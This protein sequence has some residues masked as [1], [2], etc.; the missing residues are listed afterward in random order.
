MCIIENLFVWS[1]HR[2]TGEIWHWHSQ[3]EEG[4]LREAGYYGN[5]REFSTM[6]CHSLQGLWP[7]C[8]AISLPSGRRRGAAATRAHCHGNTAAAADA[9]WG[10]GAS[11][12][13]QTGETP[14]LCQ[15]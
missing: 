1:R 5:Q 7:L 10:R 13:F 15:A 2:V 6:A 3:E 11:E 12:A 8:L 14:F 9:R 4:E